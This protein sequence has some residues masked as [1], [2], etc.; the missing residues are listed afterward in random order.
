MNY[1]EIQRALKKLNIDGYLIYDFRGSNYI[2]RD[3]LQ[4]SAF[5][6]RRWVAL[7]TPYEP[8]QFIVPKLEISQFSMEATKHLYSTH[9]EFKKYLEQFLQSTKKLAIDTSPLSNLPVVDIVPAGFMEL[10]K[11]IKK[12]II[13]IP[14]T[15]VTQYITAQWGDKYHSHKQAAKALKSSADTVM[16]FIK[17]SLQNNKSITDFD[18]SEIMKQEYKKNNLIVDD[19]I[20]IVS[21]NERTGDPHYFPSKENMNKIEKNSV[22]LIDIWARLNQEKSIYADMTLMG[23]I[24]PNPVPN[25]VL[26]RWEIIKNARDI[27][28]EYVQSNIQRDVR[29]FEVDKVVREYIASKGFGDA[30]FHRTGHSIDTHDHGKGANIDDFETHDERFLLPDTG[31]SIE[32]GI[33]KSDFGVRSEID[34]YVTPEKKAEVTTYKQEELFIL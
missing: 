14:S 4:F 33:Y 1:S 2:G 17:E 5:T 10:I 32:P 8:I 22:L 12:D 15:E 26:K 29:G 20:C 34:M 28:I 11:E 27:A 9:Q 31:F 25:E 16:K 18:A 3:I 24:G 7:I 13:L 23:W 19:D 30:F 6:T 21:T